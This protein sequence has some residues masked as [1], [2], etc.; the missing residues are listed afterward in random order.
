M[1]HQIPTELSRKIV[2]QEAKTAISEA[3]I[4]IST[5]TLWSDGSKVESGG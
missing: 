1:V 5:W 4:D 2:I 3:K